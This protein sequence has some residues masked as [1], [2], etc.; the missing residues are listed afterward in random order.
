MFFRPEA[1]AVLW[2]WREVLVAVGLVLLGMWLIFGPGLLLAVP[3][4]A[5]VLGSVALGV[6]GFQRARFRGTGDGPGA[7]Q[8]DE[9]QIAYFGPLTGGV[10]ALEN[11]ERLSLDT[12][13]RPAHWQLDVSGQ[14]ALLIPVNAAG[15]DALFDA[16]A[17]LPG[18]RT[19][20]MLTELR[21]GRRH[22]VVIW[23][24]TPLRPAHALLH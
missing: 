3:G 24:R 23:E 2:R 19:E 17:K 6:V 14:E 22:T 21:A 7:V 1:M 4:W 20:R 10:V 8:V 16:F 9:G 5:L 15:S 12:T 11:L 13:S 18:L